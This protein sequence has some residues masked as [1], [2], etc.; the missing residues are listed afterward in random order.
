MITTQSK[1]TNH[2]TCEDL[3]EFV[4]YCNLILVAAAGDLASFSQYSIEASYIVTLSQKTEMLEKI[5]GSCVDIEL[6]MA[7]ISLLSRELLLGIGK[8]CHL[9]QQL[10]HVLL[11]H[12]AYDQFRSKFDQWWLTWASK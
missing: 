4:N 2:R 9:A 3:I 6:E 1:N 10:D 11:N 7:K 8:I 5:T 12:Q